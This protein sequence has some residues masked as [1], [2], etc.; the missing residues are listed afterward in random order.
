MTAAGLS[1]GRINLEE[2][3]GGKIEILGQILGA[4]AKQI[5]ESAV[6]ESARGFTIRVIN[7]F[8]LY[9]TKG[10]NLASIQ[11]RK[12]EGSRQDAKQFTVMG[13]VI[14]E[15]LKEFATTAGDERAL[16]KSSGRLLEF[17]LTTDG[18]ALV[19]AGAMDPFKLLPLVLMETHAEAS[20]RNLMDK[21][22][23]HFS[24]SAPFD[25]GQSARRP[26]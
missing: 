19:K 9:Q 8:L 14:S 11:Q 23:P 13:I 3:R 10:L 24:A 18:A 12:P 22:L 25:P 26:A 16:I 20:V 5:R 17:S 4:D 21:R 1:L 7:P 2:P 6:T 15:V